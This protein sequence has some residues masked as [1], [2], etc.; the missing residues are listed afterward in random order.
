MLEQPDHQM[1]V[2]GPQSS[3][4]GTPSKLMQHPRVRCALAM[5]KM[6]EATPGS[7]LGQQSHD[8]VETVRRRQRAEQM[9][10]PQLSRAETATTPHAP[11][12]G[13]QLIDERVGYMNGESFQ[14]LRSSNWRQLFEHDHMHYPF[15]HYLSLQN[16]KTTFAGRYPLESRHLQLIS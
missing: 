12:P 7:L 9:H 4:P 2:D 10:P 13:Q 14:Q 8:S 15:G 3:D 5:R 1:I 16:Q 11:T 6:S